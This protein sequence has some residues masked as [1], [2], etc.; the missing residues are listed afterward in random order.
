VAASAT[1]GGKKVSGTLAGVAAVSPTS[2][3]AVGRRDLTGGVIPLIEHWNGKKWSVVPSP[4]P[5]GSAANAFLTGVAASKAGAWAVGTSAP[6]NIYGTVVLALQRG[7][8]RQL[9]SPNPSGLGNFLNAVSVSGRHVLAGGFGG[10]D[11]PVAARTLVVHLKGTAVP[12]DKTPN[13]GV[14]G[15]ANELYG[16][17]ATSTGGWAVGRT[18]AQTMILHETAGH[19]KQ[20]ASPSWPSPATSLLE[21]V[22]AVGTT[23]WAVGQ[24]TGLVSPT[25]S[26]TYSL[27]LRWTGSNWVRTPSPNR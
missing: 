19:W 26:A 18:I 7:K 21:G 16:V 15:A 1:I 27:I 2:V 20:V 10:Y 25:M 24:Y 6:K 13:P 5:G 12:L 23:A 8:W 9:K 22:T 11:N 4:D 17:A 3:W 14:P